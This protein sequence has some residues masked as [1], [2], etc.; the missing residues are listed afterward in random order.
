MMEFLIHV[1]AKPVLGIQKD[2]SASW[3]LLIFQLPKGD[4]PALQ[5]RPELHM[6]NLA[7]HRVPVSQTISHLNG[8]FQKPSFIHPEYPDACFAFPLSHALRPITCSDQGPANAQLVTEAKGFSCSVE[9]P[10]LFRAEFPQPSAS[11][12]VDIT[13]SVRAGYHPADPD[14]LVIVDVFSCHFSVTATFEASPRLYQ[15]QTPNLPDA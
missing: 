5:G 10:V 1:N 6:V 11:D 9:S 13:S 12:V 7:V 3:N 15:G 2:N 4:D 8:S 14:V